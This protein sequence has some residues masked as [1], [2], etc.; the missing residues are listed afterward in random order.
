[1]NIV[2]IGMR[3][4]GKTTVGRILAQK[5]GRDLVE[6]DELITQRAGLSIPE[7]VDKYGWAKFREIEEEITGEVSRME[8]IINASGGGVIT[9]A[10]NTARLKENGALVWLTAG[11][12]TLLKRTGQDSQRPPL[13]SGRTQRGDLEMTLAERKALYQRAADLMVDTEG[14]TPQETAEMVIKLLSKICCLIGDP[15]E[16]SLSPLIHNAGYKALGID[17]VYIPFRV[18]EVKKAIEGIR[19]LGIR[20]AS[21]TLPHKTSTLKYLD[22]IDPRAEAIGAVNT[23][24]NDEGVLSGYN[25]DGEGALKALEEVT[26]PGGK[27][28]VLIGSGG[29]ASAIAAALKDSGAELVILNRTG[30]KAREL[31]KKFNAEDGGGLEK[32][33]LITKADILI[34][35]TSVGMSPKTGQSIVPEELLHSRLTVFDIVYNPR[36]TRLITQAKEKGCA[37]VYGYKMLLYQAALQFELFTGLKAPIAVMESALTQALEGGENATHIDRR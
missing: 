6:M 33:P 20:G 8:N 3:G 36:E 24:V 26:A 4:S 21:V 27:K 5:L 1:M 18:K 12:D 25:T 22:K 2:L 23:I 16:H 35:A 34:N 9:E 14:K 32:L 28:A 29:A 19:G 17:Y 11:V 13:V 15:V 7:T 30:D 10:R 31:A 37:V